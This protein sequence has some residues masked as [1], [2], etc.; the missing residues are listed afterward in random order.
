MSS[1]RT[2]S[3]YTIR[4]AAVIASFLAAS[5]VLAG[6]E[7]VFQPLGFLDADNFGPVIAYGISADGK[8]VVGQSNSSTGLQAFRW[9]QRTGIVGLG[10]FANPGGIASS[11]ARACSADGSV[12]VGSSS[13]PNSL[14]ED[15]SPFRW[16]E[17]TG[18]VFLGSLG[19]TDGGVARGV[20]TDGSV[21]VGYSS[22]ASFGLEA[23]RWTAA[24]IVGLGDLPGGVFNSQASGVS[25][26]G[27]IVIGLASTSSS[28]YHRA[29]KWTQAT[30]MLQLGSNNFRA[31]GISRDGVFAAGSDT[32]RAARVQITNGTTLMIPHLAI[33]GLN[34][35]TDQGWAAN[36]DG[37]VV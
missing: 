18:L 16:T 22:N 19:G 28:P 35:D 23:F 17:Q 3:L 1:F 10:A 9:T 29:C 24:G 25:G 36:A 30:G 11:G 13:L 31:G 20:S 12:I 27:S 37:S 14:N 8:V 6:S 4:S 34:T 33:P 7:A 5:H 26:D 21:I 32:G 2:S 15:G